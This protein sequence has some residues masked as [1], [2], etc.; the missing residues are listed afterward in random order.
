V[1]KG[2]CPEPEATTPANPLTLFDLLTGDLDPTQ[3][4]S[5][6]ISATG[7]ASSLF[8]VR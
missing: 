8:R 3:A 7:S 1:V 4:V 6:T 5:H 2:R